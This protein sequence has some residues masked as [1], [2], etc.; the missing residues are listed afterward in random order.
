ML[1]LVRQVQ[2]LGTKTKLC[3]ASALESGCFRKLVSEI[4]TPD[5]TDYFAAVAGQ[6]KHLG[7]LKNKRR[8]DLGPTRSIL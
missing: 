2:E 1:A 3:S 5:E 4:V 8:H 6:A 7:V